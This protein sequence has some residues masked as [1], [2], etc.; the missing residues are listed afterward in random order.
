MH[1]PLIAAAGFESIELN[2]FLGSDDFPWDRPARVTEL[3]RI[4]ADVGLRIHTVHAEGGIGGYR[5]QRSEQMAIDILRAFADLAA[6]L[7]ASVV[8]FHAGLCKTL[9]PAAA[10]R[11]LHTSIDI[12]SRHAAD[13]PCRFGWENEPIGISTAE[14][15]QWI[16]DLDPSTFCFVFDNGHAH[17]A[18]STGTYLSQAG[19][20]LGGLHL[21]DNDGKKDS[22][23]FPGAGSFDWTGFLPW[24]ATTQ[25]TGPVMLELEARDRQHELSLA[26]NEIR[27]AVEQHIFDQ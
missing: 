17:I 2:C 5:G 27:E 10:Q 19:E 9:D 26:L 15:L 11:Q 16:G 18:D 25:Y 24:L 21:N 3:A 8:P 4:A 20:V 14:H 12:L 7:G 22:H 13:L 6:E 1:L 23:V